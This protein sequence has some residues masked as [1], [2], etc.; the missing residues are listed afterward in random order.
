M[1]TDWTLYGER[2]QDAE[3]GLICECTR[4]SGKLENKYDLHQFPFDQQTLFICVGARSMDKSLLELKVRVPSPSPLHV[5][6]M[7]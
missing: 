2:H 7:S 6:P 4:F 5:P 3:R 1:P